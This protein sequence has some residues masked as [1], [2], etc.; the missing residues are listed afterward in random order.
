[1]NKK[2]ETK[3]KHDEEISRQRKKL[4]DKEVIKTNKVDFRS[5]GSNGSNG[6]AYNKNFTVGCF[7]SFLY[8]N[9]NVSFQQQI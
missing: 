7:S 8:D 5:N 3:V 4:K 9:N 6:S 2:M 1:M